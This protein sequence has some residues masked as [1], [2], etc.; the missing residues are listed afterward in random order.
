[1]GHLMPL[2]RF[3]RPR[4]DEPRQAVE[5]AWAFRMR[6]GRCYVPPSELAE[7]SPIG[8]VR[9]ALSKRGRIEHAIERRVRAGIVE[10]DG[11]LTLQRAEIEPG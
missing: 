3:G 9:A 10:G 6:Q 5:V 7:S 1:M 4:W 2:F 11:T 8:A